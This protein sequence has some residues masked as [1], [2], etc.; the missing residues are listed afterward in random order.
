[1]SKKPKLPVERAATRIAQQL[2][3]SRIPN[4]PE[5][6][7]QEFYISHNP[8][9]VCESLPAEVT[10]N[11][12]VFICSGSQVYA[13][14]MKAYRAGARAAHREARADPGRTFANA[15]RDACK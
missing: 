8:G 10:G 13:A 11:N 14:L 6:L 15:L 4:T 2:A 3:K 9:E 5:F 7:G 1:M 12:A